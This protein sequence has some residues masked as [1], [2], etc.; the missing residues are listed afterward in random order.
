VPT[1]R[2]GL[3]LLL[4]CA[5]LALAAS[6]DALYSTLL[7][8]ITEA[9]K[10]MTD[11]PFL[12]MGLFVLLSAASAMLAFASSAALVPVAVLIWGKALCALLLWSGWTLGGM[13]AYGI[14]RSLGRPV[15]KSLLSA[16]ILSRYE[17]RISRHAPFGLI[18]LFQLALP[19]EVPG[20]VLGLARYRFWKYMIALMV[21]ELPYAVGTVY[22]GES[23]LDRRLLLFLGLGAASALFS[24]FAFRLLHRRLYDA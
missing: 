3:I 11:R 15:V 8:V 5:A 23:L 9:G 22:L 10:L 4:L 1:W 7:R 18:L 13:T 19:S 24:V 21:S 6:S 2:R 20:Y 17:N 14:G 12:G 16:E